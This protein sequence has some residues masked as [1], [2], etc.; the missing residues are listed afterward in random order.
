MIIYVNIFS[1][2][3]SFHLLVDIVLVIDTSDSVDSSDLQDAIDF[4]YNVTKW[5]KIGPQDIQIAVVTYASDV[6]EQFDLNDYVTNTTLLQA[7]ESLKSTLKT[8]GGTYTFDALTYV[9]TTSFLS[10]RGS[11]NNSNKAV[12][13]MTDGQSTNYPLTVKTANDLRTDLNAEV[14]AIGVG[15]DSKRNAEIQ[16][17]ANDPDSYFVYYVDSFDYLCSVIPSLVPKLG[18]V[19]ICTYESYT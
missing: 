19:E 10:M 15:T 12:L 7:I 1:T 4:I 2:I 16:G 5:L 18:N 14:F 11:R 8:G 6:K 13:V 9:K 3:W 17:I